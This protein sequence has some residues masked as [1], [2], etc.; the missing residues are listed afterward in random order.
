MFDPNPVFRLARVLLAGLLLAALL[1]VCALAHDDDD[2]VPIARVG[3]LTVRLI[4]EADIEEFI[5]RWRTDLL[6]SLPNSNHHLL[7]NPGLVPDEFLAGQ[8]RQDPDVAFVDLNWIVQG[9]E[10][11]R[12]MVIDAVGGGWDEF[13]F[14]NMCERIG[15]ADAHTFSTGLGTLVAV[16]D[17]GVDEGHEAFDGRLSELAYDFIEMEHEAKDEGNGIDDD[18]DG[19]IDEGYGHGTMVAGL[20]VLIA[21]QAVILPIRIL[22]DEGRTDLFTMATGIEYA[23]DSGADVINMSFGARLEALPALDYL[24][25]RCAAEG[26]IPV[27]GAGNDNLLEPP[28]YPG[29]LSDVIMV[30]ALDTLGAKADFAD[31]HPNV[32]V[33]APGV[34]IR[35]S[36]PEEDGDIEW[37]IGAGCSFSTA[38]VSGEAALILS[39]NPL[40]THAE[41]KVIIRGAVVDIYGIPGN[42]AYQGMLGSGMIYLPYAVDGFSTAAPLG[43]AAENLTALA[44]PNPTRSSVRFVLPGAASGKSELRIYD[45]AGRLVRGLSVGAAESI[46]WDGRD[47]D[48][49]RAATGGYFA[50]MRAGNRTYSASVVL[51]R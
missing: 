41:V 45:L 35:S 48:G 51:I 24:F 37:G 47:G 3:Q 26:V 30:T 13:E 36:I 15:L 10:A 17:T 21:P 4:P 2:D 12:Q 1:P 31:Y 43:P 34:G 38:L 42:E 11:V 33:A 9:P 40:L 29:R 46:V 39:Q 32:L 20:I 50:R 19:V 7:G 28:L 22:D 16:L 23:L 14:Q 5:G 6:A 8:M 27:A 44:Y 49:K 18:G 25:E